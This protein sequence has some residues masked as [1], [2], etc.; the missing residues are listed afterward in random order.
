MINENFKFCNINSIKIYKLPFFEESRGD[1]SV[2]ETYKEC[3]FNITRIFSVR[4]PI[5]TTRGEHAH[6]EC[7]QFLICLNGAVEVICDD[8]KN[9]KS[10]LLDSPG[11]GLYVPI[12]IWQV[13][14][15]MKENSV[16]LFL[17][18][19]IYNVKEYI[20]DYDNFLEYRSG[21]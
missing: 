10:F 4:A 11:I 18:D 20:N 2:I 15:Y 9:S 14:K 13:Q 5:N 21:K 17:C 19:Q 7:K 12:S 6:K 16:L 3:P 8:G 1:L